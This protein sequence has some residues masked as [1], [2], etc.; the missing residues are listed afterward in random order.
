MSTR[1]EEYVH[2]LWWLFVLSGIA[3][4]TFGILALFLPGLTLA[5][6]VV[7][8]A[9]YAIV[10]GVIELVHGF[11]S[12][13]KRSSWWFTLLVGLVM[14]GVGVYLIRHP[15]T[16]IGTFIVLIGAVLLVRGIFD[17]IVAAFFVKRNESRWLWVISG[18]L[19]ILAGIFLWS[20][21]ASGGIAFVWVLGLYALI[22]GSISLA[23]A[24]S[25]RNSYQE[26]EAGARDVADKVTPT[27]NRGGRVRRA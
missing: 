24:F 8:F 9:I 5:L 15:E 11:A 23:Y 14:L 21:P 1:V 26:I 22:V 3:T 13:G 25:V 20:N 7:I 18:V 2:D 6:L 27:P 16:A 12:I 4:I 10:I 17:L 19:G